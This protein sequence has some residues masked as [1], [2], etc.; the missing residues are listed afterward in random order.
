MSSSADP[1]QVSATVSGAIL[2]VSTIIIYAAAH[3]FH[4]VL[5]VNDITS[6]ATGVGAVA[7]SVWKTHA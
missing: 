1:S 6:L 5:S 7:G 3:L 4:I 2:G